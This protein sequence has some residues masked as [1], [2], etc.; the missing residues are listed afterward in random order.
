MVDSL[1]GSERH[2][3]PNLPHCKPN[4]LSTLMELR[5]RPALKT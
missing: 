5:C 2:G 3:D 1:D 4:L